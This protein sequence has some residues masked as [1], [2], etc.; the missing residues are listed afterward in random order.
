[1]RESQVQGSGILS[2]ERA[3]AA[4]GPEITALYLA[5]RTD[6]LP[7][8]RRVHSDAAVGD[9]VTAILL[10]DFETWVA[11][12]GGRI[13]G[14]MA[15]AG[16]D[17]DQLYLLPGYYRQGIGSALLAKARERSPDGL[18]LFTFQRNMRARAFYEAHG[19]SIVDMNDG[20]R[21]EENEPD[22]LYAWRPQT[23]L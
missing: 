5:S 2:V 18:R 21:N 16:D 15:V 17:L 1:M 14:F 8:L 20:A 13:V 19:F 7:Y 4:D 9:W 6:A 10:R 23:N 11:R 3:I 12:L 22:I